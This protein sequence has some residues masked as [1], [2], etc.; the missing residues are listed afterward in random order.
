MKKVTCFLYA[1]ILGIATLFFCVILS[2]GILNMRQNAVGVFVFWVSVVSLPIAAKKYVKWRYTVINL[3]LY[4]ALYFPISAY[5]W[6]GGGRFF[7]QNGG[8]IVIPDL[9][10]AL[11][12][13]F[14]LWALEGI[15]Y[16]IFSLLCRLYKRNKNVKQV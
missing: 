8:F 9:A 1:I 7:F 10:G 15:V 11:L 12:M 4:Y 3:P 14:L 16:A 5:P 2:D 13:A 6:N